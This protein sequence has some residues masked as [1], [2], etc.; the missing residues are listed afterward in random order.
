MTEN[1]KQFELVRRLN[2]LNDI[3]AELA[4]ANSKLQ[5]MKI[6]VTNAGRHFSLTSDGGSSRQDTWP[7]SDLVH[8]QEDVIARLRSEADS[9]IGELRDMGIS[10]DIFTINGK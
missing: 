2:R 9:L 10:G 5:D 6:K 4:V 8:S 1:E 7:S 3:R